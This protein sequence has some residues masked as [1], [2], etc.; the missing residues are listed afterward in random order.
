MLKKRYLGTFIQQDLEKKMVF[1]GGPRQVGKTTL[2]R[3]ILG[4]L[5]NYRYYNWDDKQ[6]RQDL[7]N[8]RLSENKLLIFDEVHKYKKWKNLVKGFFDKLKDKHQFLITGS[9]RLDLYRKGGDSLQGRYHYYRLHPFSLA[10][11]SQEE[12]IYTKPPEKLLIPVQSEDKNFQRLFQFGGFPEPL[13][14]QNERDLRRWHNERIERLFKDDILELEMIRDLSKVKLL[15]DLLPERV[16]SP[17]SINALRLEIEV[18]HKAVSKWLDILESFYYHFR[19]Y[20]YSRSSSKSL[21]KE[22]KLYLWDWSEI[23]DKGKRFENMVASHLL[24]YSHF[25]YDYEGY[26]TELFYFRDTEKR[27]VDFLMTLDGKPWFSVEVK[28]NKIDLPKNQLYFMKKSNTPYNYCV[29]Y[30]DNVDYTKGGIRVIS[31]NRFLMSLV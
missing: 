4:G 21:K 30:K 29:V 12:V 9:A 22:A 3:D 17:L 8:S 6:D 11:Y 24:K 15:A 20:P 25:L 16:C 23:V 26:K 14:S 7:L 19:I 1:V 31:A 18:S 28:M 10:E 5:T 2:S 13:L 27:E